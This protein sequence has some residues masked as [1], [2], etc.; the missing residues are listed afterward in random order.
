MKKNRKTGLFISLVLAVLAVLL[1]GTALA[2]IYDGVWGGTTNQGHP[3]T[4]TV[5]NG[6]VKSYI[7]DV[8]FSGMYCSGSKNIEASYNSSG[9]L[10]T[11]AQFAEVGYSE[12]LS[13][14]F[15]SP[16]TAT[17]NMNGTDDWCEAAYNVSWTATKE[18]G[19]GGGGDDAPVTGQPSGYDGSWTGTTS[20]GQAIAFMLT[21]GSISWLS[22]EAEFSGIYCSGS[23]TSVVQSS[24]PLANGTFTLSN[25]DWDLSGTLSSTSTASGTLS[26]YNAH[27]SA[28]YSVTWT[29]TKWDGG[30]GCQD[31]TD[32]DGDGVP[33]CE[34]AFPA[35][36][37]MASVTSYGGGNLLFLEIMGTYGASLANIV[38]LSPT[39]PL[40]NSNGYPA[41]HSFP[42]GIMSFNIT[43]ITPGSTVD[44]NITLPSIPANASLFKVEETGFYEYPLVSVNGTTATIT[45]TDG[46]LGD[47]DGIANGTIV[48]PLG[49]AVPTQANAAAPGDGG[50]GGG[51]CFIQSAEKSR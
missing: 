4:F 35:D 32:S 30:D 13:G 5:V 17:G 40:L 16:T 37:A 42:Y 43:G 27:C 33:N 34:D 50:G 36:P 45:L 14:V 19:G 23:M 10:I 28:S 15:T 24:I 21:N 6:F 25:S 18:G 51:G 7:L 41:D 47:A 9:I 22:V 49:M 11:N 31:L 8:D 39:D 1:P 12:N 3:I 46:G 2:S 38:A 29:A 44:V 26:G 48:D 20:Q